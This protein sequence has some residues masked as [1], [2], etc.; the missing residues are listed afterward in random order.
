MNVPVVYFKD[1]KEFKMGGIT[2]M[3]R[4]NVAIYEDKDRKKKLVQIVLSL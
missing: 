3:T 1:Q 4:H 2:L